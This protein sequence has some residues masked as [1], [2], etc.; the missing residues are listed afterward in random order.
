MAFKI[1][2]N[3][4]ILV[5]RFM[6]PAMIIIKDNKITVKTLPKPI[7]H[8]FHIKGALSSTETRKLLS[9]GSLSPRVESVDL[10]SIKDFKALRIRRNLNE[11]AE[12]LGS[13]DVKGGVFEV[14]LNLNNGEVIKLL[15]SQRAYLKLRNAVLKFK[16]K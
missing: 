1:I 4:L 14:V 11:I 9:L 5:D 10:L 12:L 16:A 15:L 13:D 6:V 3:A 8:L 2:R 7:K